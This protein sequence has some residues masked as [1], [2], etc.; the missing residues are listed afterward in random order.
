MIFVVAS[1][2]SMGLTLKPREISEPLRRPLLVLTTLLGNFVL[3]P[4]MAYAAAAALPLD[5]SHETGLLLLAAAAGAPFL[6]KL[7]ELARGDAGLSV[8]VM[9]LQTVGTI[10]FLPM[11]LP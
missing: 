7:V 10:I 6:P 3:V 1:M 2:A 8:G 5:Q 4:L 9:L 11:A